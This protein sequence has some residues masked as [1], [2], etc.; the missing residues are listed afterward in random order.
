MPLRVSRPLLEDMKAFAAEAL[1]YLGDRTAEALAADR[2]RFL[3][4]PR[5]CELVGEAAAQVPRSVRE[6]LNAIPFG[7]AISMGN[8]LIHGCGTVDPEVVERTIREDFPPLIMA[9]ASALAK[10]LPDVNSDG[11]VGEHGG[12]RGPSF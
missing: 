1:Q 12:G 2:M 8:R 4:V 11:S 5:A 7:P 9:L 10:A 6:A 3:A